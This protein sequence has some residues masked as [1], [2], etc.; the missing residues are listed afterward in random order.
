MRLVGLRIFMHQLIGVLEEDFRYWHVYTYQTVN[1][2]PG[3]TG[4]GKLSVVFVGQ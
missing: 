1:G 4:N 3:N 2:Y